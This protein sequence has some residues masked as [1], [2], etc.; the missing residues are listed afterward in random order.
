MIGRGTRPVPP[1]RCQTGPALRTHP[2][3][4]LAQTG[5]AAYRTHPVVELAQTGL[6]A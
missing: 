4:E 2:V 3:V 5:L 1:S 6:A